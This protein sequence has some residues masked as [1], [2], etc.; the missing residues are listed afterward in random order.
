MQGGVGSVGLSVPT[1]VRGSSEAGY[2]VSKMDWRQAP[3]FCFLGVCIQCTCVSHTARRDCRAAAGWEGA[4]FN[5]ASRANAD[6]KGFGG[7]VS[8]LGSHGRHSL[9]RCSVVTQDPRG[10]RQYSPA[11]GSRRSP[12]GPS[13]R[14]TGYCRMFPQYTHSAWR[15]TPH[16]IR[17]LLVI[18]GVVIVSWCGEPPSSVILGLGV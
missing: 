4:A 5:G 13:G 3:T 2:R 17:L 1:L 7:R 11:T 12:D 14:G 18:R 16:R 8:V 9:R 6:S 15:Q 10:Y